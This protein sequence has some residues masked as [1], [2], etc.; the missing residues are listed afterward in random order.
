VVTAN[1]L[2]LR[3][4]GGAL[5]IAV[6]GALANAVLGSGAGDPVRLTDAVQRIFAGIVVLAALMLA[7]A[8]VL[9]RGRAT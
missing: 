1:N 4:V 7:A 9:P 5:G 6:F 2:F 8:T 3:S